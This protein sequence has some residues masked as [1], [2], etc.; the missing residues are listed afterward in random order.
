MARTTTT[1]IE[2]WNTLHENGPWPTR[3]MHNTELAKKADM[4]LQIERYNDAAGEMQRLFADAISKGE[5]FRAI[6]SR[7][8]MSHIAHQKDNIQVNPLMNLK[9][10]IEA[11]QLHP[12]T[13]FIAENLFLIQCGNVIKE[14]HNFLNDF[15]KSMKATGASNGQTIAGCVSTGVHGSALDIG[16]VQDYVVGLSIIT[17]PGPEDRIYLERASKPALSDAF[18]GIIQSRIIRDD[19]MFNAALVS[20]GSFGFIHGVVIE[21]EDR[22]LLKRY[23]KKIS[24]DLAL[25]LASTLDFENSLFKIPVET[26]AAGRGLRPYHYKV[27]INPYVNDNEYVVEV[28]YKKPYQSG[29]PDPVPAIRTSLYKDLV[30][31]FIKI[32]QAWQNSIPKLIQIL[33]NSILPPVDAEATGMLSEIFYDAGYQGPAFACSVGVDHR[34]SPKALQLL[35]D[36]AKDEGPVPGIYAMRFVKQSGATLAFTRFPV[37]CML[38][39]DGLIW[40]GEP[41]G[42]ITLE[43]FCTR[44]IEVLQENNIVFTLHWGKNADWAFPGLTEYMYGARAGEWKGYRN[45]LLSPEARTLFS[46]DFLRHT[47]LDQ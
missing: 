28:M 36:L 46:N 5:G 1:A 3:F 21:A 41:H 6:G 40:N 26:D 23:V 9:I 17:G 2:S 4:P 31:L 8:S 19:G 39:I 20:L 32:A 13:D 10:K 24:K 29:Y 15:G 25:D 35:V 22:F 42:M 16:S 12:D 38:E 7:W 45:E 18:A 27:F 34:D 11:S 30:Y 33:Q 47:G 44:I 37:T 43:R 14:I